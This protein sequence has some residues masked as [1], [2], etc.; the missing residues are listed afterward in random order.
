MARYRVNDVVLAFND[1]TD[2]NGRGVVRSVLGDTD[3]GSTRDSYIVVFDLDVNDED[4]EEEEHILDNDDIVSLLERPMRETLDQVV[5]RMQSA[6]RVS[7]FGADAGP[8]P[9]GP[10]DPDDFL[11]QPEILR[12]YTPSNGTINSIPST[13]PVPITVNG[14]T[15]AT[16]GVHSPTTHMYNLFAEHPVAQYIGFEIRPRTNGGMA[17]GIAD[18]VSPPPNIFVLPHIVERRGERTLEFRTPEGEVWVNQFGERNLRHHTCSRDTFGQ[19]WMREEDYLA[20][21][22]SRLGYKP[23]PKNKLR[24]KYGKMP[25]IKGEEH[26]AGSN[27]IA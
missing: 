20:G 8:T 27:F 19:L 23:I 6:R 10:I 18:I 1:L 26:Y 24:K 3:H 17:A 4:D 15:I 2:S 5:P 9:A 21:E 22:A 14:I 11:P 25:E 12:Y 7:S 16:R 13:P